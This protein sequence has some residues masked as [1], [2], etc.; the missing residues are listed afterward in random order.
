M[1][2][3]SSL[4]VDAGGNGG[5]PRGIAPRRRPYVQI[6]SLS[7]ANRWQAFA[8]CNRFGNDLP[9][10]RVVSRKWERQPGFR[11][12]DS[13]PNEQ[14]LEV[15]APAP[16]Y[17]LRAQR[18]FVF[19]NSGSARRRHVNRSLTGAKRLSGVQRGP[20]IRP[21]DSRRREALGSRR[22]NLHLNDTWLVGFALAC[23]K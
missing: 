12:G 5:S 19:K 9:V 17:V 4:R 3:T 13:V 22:H 2:P 6:K 16:E 21:S 15:S 11:A 14:K 20:R 8:V 23:G 10:V 18:S 7:S 1:L